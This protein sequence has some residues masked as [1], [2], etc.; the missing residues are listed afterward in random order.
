MVKYSWH[1][2]GLGWCQPSSRIFKIEKLSPYNHSEKE[3][4]KN[5][6]QFRH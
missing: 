4:K 3:E 2:W 1:Y 5:E 6:K